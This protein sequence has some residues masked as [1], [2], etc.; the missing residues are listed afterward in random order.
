M[1]LIKNRKMY[2]KKILIQLRQSGNER[3]VELI[4]SFLVDMNASEW[5]QCNTMLVNCEWLC[6][7]EIDDIL[8]LS[9]NSLFFSFESFHYKYIQTIH[10][11]ANTLINGDE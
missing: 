5:Y 8:F 4:E 11:I 1:Y 3:C 2:L 9:T 7:L 6:C 10:K